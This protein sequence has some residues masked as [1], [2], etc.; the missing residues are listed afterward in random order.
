MIWTI[1]PLFVIFA[2]AARGGEKRMRIANSKREFYSILAPVAKEMEEKY[3][4]K[5]EIII[6]QAALETG[7]GQK[8][9]DNNLFNIK[10]SLSDPEYITVNVR[11]YIP[12]KGWVYVPVRFKK[13]DS[14][15]DSVEDYVRLIRL[16]NRYK[17]A[18]AQ[19][20]NPERFFEELQKAGYATDPDYALK[21]KAIYVAHFGAWNV[22]EA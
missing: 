16:S 8:V 4:I 17:E 7:W 10:A 14:I 19:R 3:G 22:F 1:L 5:A 13:Y 2:L 18:W 20:K 11:E 9:I 6:T 12:G 21:L 15:R